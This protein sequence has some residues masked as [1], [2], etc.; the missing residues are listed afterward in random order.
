MTKKKN[1][2]S[3]GSP[4]GF[5][6]ESRSVR[7]YSN[8]NG[9][10]NEYGYDYKRSADG[11]EEFT[12]IGDIPA[13]FGN[14]FNER[15]TNLDRQFSEF[16]NIFAKSI[17]SVTDLFPSFA[18]FKGN[19]DLPRLLIGKEPILKPTSEEPSAFDIPYDIQ[20]DENKNEL[21]VLVEL[22]GFSRED[23]KIKL[24]KKGLYLTGTNSSKQIETTIPLDNE[25][26]TTGKISASL[27]N[28]ILEVKLKLLDSQQD[29]GFNIPIN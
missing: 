17:N 10:E 28:G 25:I 16:G 19:V 21:Y 22:P 8:L 26:D 9:G 15:V 20:R 5:Y 23:V 6:E 11:K 27:R 12:E 1:I 2:D 3:D 4:E 7:F 18:K 14:D 13:D 24:T 29:K